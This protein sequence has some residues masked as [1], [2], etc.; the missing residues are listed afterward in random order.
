[1][2]AIFVL[3][4]AVLLTVLPLARAAVHYADSPDTVVDTRSTGLPA[5]DQVEASS[6]TFT[7]YVEISWQPVTGATGYRV[8]RGLL[9]DASSAVN[10]ATRLT[11]TI[12]EDTTA[13][14]GVT[15]HYWV[16]AEMDDAR[17]AFSAPAQGFRQDPR[18][19]PP[20][21][22]N[23]TEGTHGEFVRLTWN[24]SGA[25]QRYELYRAARPVESIAQALSTTITLGQYDDPAPIG[26]TFYYW[27]ASN[28]N[29]FG[30]GPWAGP[31]RGRAGRSVTWW[32]LA[33]DG[34]RANF[35]DSG[36]MN[37]TTPVG[38]YPA[39]DYG[40]FDMAGQVFEWVW[41]FQRDDWYEQPES[42]QA[43]TRGPAFGSTRVIRGGSWI[44]T[45]PFIRVAYRDRSSPQFQWFN[46]GFRVVRIP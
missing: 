37:G 22:F 45:P 13:D 18:P 3:L 8:F 10:L 33:V 44:N 20:A 15:Y 17:S 7:E 38:I 43:D 35:R 21:N 32:D 42:V 1:M 11:S 23:A 29:Q 19:S 25:A 31:V 30:T 12:F 2:K 46:T 39:N 40:L 34:T 4:P 36:G 41:D 16:Q 14:P 6:G 5:P 27:V 24:L 28:N 26:W 9:P